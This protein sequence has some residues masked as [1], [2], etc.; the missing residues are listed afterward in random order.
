MT[1]THGLNDPEP[2]FES[3]ERLQEETN[4]KSHSHSLC[5]TCTSSSLYSLLPW[6]PSFRPKEHWDNNTL[7]LPF[8]PFLPHTRPRRAVQTM[9][10]PGLPQIPLCSPLSEAQQRFGR[11]QTRRCQLK[12]QEVCWSHM[13]VVQGSGGESPLNARLLVNNRSL[14]PEERKVL[15]NEKPR[16]DWDWCAH[17]EDHQK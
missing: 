14:S 7:P 13:L 1:M 16:A 3:S 12:L 15:T 5:C 2:A 6:L 17:I 8:L 4:P 11:I 10:S 9:T